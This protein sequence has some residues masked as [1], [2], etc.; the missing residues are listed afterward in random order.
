MEL[1]RRCQGTKL[2]LAHFGGGLP[3]LS[4]LRK[5]VREYLDLIRFDT[6][7]MPFIFDPKALR[8]GVDL[9]GADRFLFG[10]DYPLLKRKRYQ[11]FF[12]DASLSAEE[13]ELVSGGAARKFLFP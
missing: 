4:C 12:L 5:E 2:I 13:T 8:V 11:K 9:L 1:V 10:S 6:A 3:L 7:A